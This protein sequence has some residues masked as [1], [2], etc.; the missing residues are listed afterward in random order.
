M[1][2][3]RH[4]HRLFGR[5]DLGLR[6]PLLYALTFG[7][8]FLTGFLRAL[9]AA[10]VLLIV[11]L[12]TVWWFGLHL[13]VNL[14]ALVIG[15][16]PLLVSLLTLVFPFG[17]WFWQQSSGGR[18]PTGHEQAAMDLALAQL[19]EADPGLRSPARWFVVDQTDPNAA[20]YGDSLMVTRGLLDS[21]YLAAT[22]AH[23]LSHLAS[24]DGRVSAAL[25]R[26]VIGPQDPIEP[27]IPVV[28]WVLSGRAARDLMSI[29]WAMYWRSREPVSDAFARRLGQGRE[30]A[31][32]LSLYPDRPT[33]WKPFGTSTH[34]WT[35]HRIEALE[36]EDD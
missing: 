34:P 33:P 27:L 29:P 9:V 2:D 12:F 18:R 1:K 32:V 13:P 5:K 28:G 23:E 3:P 4:R 10:L 19:R 17:G 16:A 22:V 25:N 31:G 7:L 26:M 8:Q 30:L 6:W 11:N 20:A 14:L 21:P 15:Y 24:S 35:E 36:G